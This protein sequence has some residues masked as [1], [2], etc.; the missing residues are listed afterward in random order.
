MLQK[1]NCCF[2]N[3]FVLVNYQKLYKEHILSVRTN[4][5]QKRDNLQV[6]GQ[7]RPFKNKV[8]LG[9]IFISVSQ[10]VETC[11][12][13]INIYFTLSFNFIYWRVFSWR[14]YLFDCLRGICQ[15]YLKKYLMYFL[16]EWAHTRISCGGGE[17]EEEG[18]GGG[19]EDEEKAVIRFPKQWRHKDRT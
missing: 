7:E 6:W 10:T 11:R 17:E 14:Y 8:P 16:R 1:T 9:S 3:Y 13:I 12:F 15:L 18:R 19:E 5:K 2:D 4:L